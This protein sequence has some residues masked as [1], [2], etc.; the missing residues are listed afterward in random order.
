MG[1]KYIKNSADAT[2]ICRIASDKNRVF[3]FT[4]KKFDK[5]NNV[6]IS[7]GYTEVSDE[8]IELLKTESSTYAYYVQKGKLSVADNL[9]YESM[10]AEQQ[11]AALRNEN[12]LLKKQL[13]D[14]QSVDAAQ[15]ETKIVEQSKEIEE[16]KSVI[17][18]QEIKIEALDT[19]LAKIFSEKKNKKD[20]VKENAADDKK[21]D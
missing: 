10:S 20:V 21:E 12:A 7:N 18:E 1:I 5:R 17:S 13:K 2:I 16:L 4:A 15:F 3:K 11:I 19:Q 9:P 14:A 6:I 8:E